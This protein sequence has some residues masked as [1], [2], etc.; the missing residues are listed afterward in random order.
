[1]QQYGEP[2]DP[3]LNDQFSSSFTKTDI[4]IL[5]HNRQQEIHIYPSRFCLKSSSPVLASSVRILK[6]TWK[7]GH[8]FITPKSM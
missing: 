1:M 8:N 2:R 7:E 6:Q 5:C 4:R 3:S